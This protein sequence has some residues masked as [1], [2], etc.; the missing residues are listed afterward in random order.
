MNTRFNIV[1]YAI[2][3]ACVFFLTSGETKGQGYVQF[4]QVSG[5]SSGCAGVATATYA[6]AW[7]NGL[8]VNN[9]SI[10]G[11]GYSA[12]ADSTGDNS[13]VTGTK[14]YYLQWGSSGSVTA[15]VHFT[16][17][18]STTTSSYS[19]TTIIT[20][21]GSISGTSPICEG[22]STNLSVSGNSGTVTFQKKI[23]GVWTDIGSNNTGN[24]SV[25][26]EFRA[27]YSTVCETDYT[28]PITINIT[29]RVSI[30]SVS[31]NPTYRYVGDDNSY[32]PGATVNASNH[33]GTF[34][35]TIK[36]GSNNSVASALSTAYNPSLIN[37]SSTFTGSATVAVT[38]YGCDNSTATATTSVTVNPIPTATFVPVGTLPSPL[39]AGTVA[40]YKLLS[41]DQ[42][43]S[44]SNVNAPSITGGGSNVTH[45][46]EAGN[47]WSVTWSSDGTFDVS[48]WIT[49]DGRT[50]TNQHAGYSFNV[51]EAIPGT[52]SFSG[53]STM[54]VG[55]SQ[56]S[57]T[58][59]ISGNSHSVTYWS[60]PSG[61]SGANDTGWTQM[62]SNAYTNLSANTNF[63]A[64]LSFTDCG[65]KY[66]NVI[67]ATIAPMPIDILVNGPAGVCENNN[68][69]KIVLN[70]GE[71]GV[72]YRL[73]KN[74]NDTG[75]EIT[76][77]GPQET[78][79][80]IEFPN[81]GVGLY[82]V[83]ATKGTCPLQM[84]GT[85]D[86]VLLTASPFGVST[87]PVQPIS[88]CPG[89]EVTIETTG[90]SQ[91][92]W[93]STRNDLTTQQM[94]A[95]SFT[96]T[97]AESAT[98]SVNGVDINCRLPVSASIAVNVKPIPN[99]SSQSATLCSGQTT[100]FQV[101]STEG[102]TFTWTVSPPSSVSGT[103]SSSSPLANFG[104]IQQTLTTTASSPETV[105]YQITPTLNG[106]NGTARTATVTLK[107]T[108]QITVA[109][110]NVFSSKDF[111]I[112]LAPT[113]TGTNVAWTT[114]AAS[115]VNVPPSNATQSASF[116]GNI[117]TS[118]PADGTVTY[119]LTPT[120][121]GCQ[122]TV[123]N[124]VMTVF[125][126]PV[127]QASINPLIKGG[128]ASV[129]TTS[130][131]LI[132][133]S[134]NWHRNEVSVITAQSVT[135]RT[136]GTYQIL[137]TRGG[138]SA[139]TQPL[140]LLSTINGQ[141]LNYVITD[142][143]QKP[144]IVTPGA[145]TMS[146]VDSVNQ[147]IQYID[148]LGRPMETVVTQGSPT[149]KDVLVP[150]VYDAF[151]REYK[152]FLPIT[153]GDDGSYKSVITESDVYSDEATNDFYSGGSPKV[154][155]DD[156]PYAK[157]LYD[158]TP[159]NRVVKQGSPGTEWQ[160]EGANPV[161]KEYLYNK[162]TPNDPL[163]VY[164]FKYHPAGGTVTLGT[165]PAAYYP[166]NALSAVKTT[167]EESNHVIE[168]T[169]KEGRVVCKK[170]WVTST[171]Y[172]CTYYLYDDFG[173]LS[174]VL[175]PEAITRLG[176]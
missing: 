77:P 42:N 65:T 40:R 98:Y 43:V 48:F 148:G 17:G 46:S 69:A 125:A 45:H 88:I 175:P 24:L 108:P 146:S 157:S 59:N 106:C 26:T 171:T 75:Q 129:L 27:R 15:T 57:G 152:T 150:N 101:S 169:D 87:T 99:L 161:I 105:V 84:T 80:R 128:A 111:T 66:S 21:A 53:P 164:M 74:N 10:S 8:S 113:I 109:N 142:V 47:E 149:R 49:K 83:V 33:N 153:K 97:P 115:G 104:A 22:T 34:G 18:T 160:P 85:P 131:A 163:A 81:Q 16:N 173:N 39:C 38:A 162:D 44:I 32:G 67:S 14:T 3:F 76:G 61:C 107:P 141:N 139:W 143:I 91:L 36:D 96:I 100:N 70:Y 19:F 35:W 137:V 64:K 9:V 37:W 95:P 102:T 92:Q 127:I 133:G 31:V 54:C 60:C 156:A 20:E 166:G 50:W 73:F 12:Y 118:A 78:G 117:T 63:R 135:T 112:D 6:V 154:A 103:S 144:G 120:H 94:T 151:G 126:L 56:A 123:K 116:S 136:P 176:N 158:N 5:G 29:P 138:I 86:V 168:F 130:P 55:T 41:T 30:S 170:V 4:T 52:I 155:S 134:G 172:A 147:S 82:K 110:Q 11:T 122:G 167:D 62:G 71:D 159:L 90:G 51:A 1:V 140:Y 28:D 25:A 165:G 72:K 89:T 121:D 174:I 114:T 68:N 23:S 58:I 93:G 7:G 13:G 132:S 79:G 2:V 145:V 119:V 124:V